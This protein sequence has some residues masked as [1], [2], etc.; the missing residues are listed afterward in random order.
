MPYTLNPHLHQYGEPA[1]SAF[2]AKHSAGRPD[3]SLLG[4]GN[5]HPT[6]DHV[7]DV[8]VHGILGG[9][10]AMDGWMDGRRDGWTMFDSFSVP[11]RTLPA[12]IGKN[13]IIHTNQL[14][15][16]S[17]HSN[18]TLCAWVSVVTTWW[19]LG[20]CGCAMVRMRGGIQVGL[21]VDCLSR[22]YD[23]HSK[24]F[25][26]LLQLD[27]TFAGIKQLVTKNTSDCNPFHAT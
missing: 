25:R 27:M 14:L 10:S 12:F 20:L 4:R 7:H 11:C 17:L 13:C 15:Q 5:A 18:W 26:G 8:A 23:V 9:G 19:Y 2:T 24:S 3:G 21:A 22:T 6:E 16:N 1:T